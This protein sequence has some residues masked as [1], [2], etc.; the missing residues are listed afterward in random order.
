MTPANKTIRLLIVDDHPVVTQGLVAMLS[1]QEDIEVVAEAGTGKE[2]IES[3]ERHA[4]DVTLMDLAL[5]D[6]SGVDAILAIRKSNPDARVIVLTTFGGDMRSLRAL[7]AGALGYLLKD[8][9]R[10]DLLDTIRGVHQGSRR[11]PREIALDLAEHCSD[12]ALTFREIEVLR[13]VACGNSNKMVA[14]RLF[15]SEDTVKTHMRN[16]VSKLSANDR[17]H[18]VTI[19]LRRGFFSLLDS[20]DGARP[21]GKDHPI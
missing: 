7:K 12:E 10:K 9:G 18:A 19:A 20:I 15:V 13:E 8:A 17:T 21:V 1:Y 16:I 6:M 4:P 3:F 5:P 2:A 11:M 14:Q